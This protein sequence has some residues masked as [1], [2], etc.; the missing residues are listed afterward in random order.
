MRGLR[1]AQKISH[2]RA[3]KL[4]HAHGLAGG[5]HLVS[6]LIIERHSV[7]VERH[8]RLLQKTHSACKHSQRLQAE[9]VEL[10]Q[11]RK[12]NPFHVELR[13]GQ[14]R[15]GIAIKRRKLRQRTIPDHHARGVSGGVAVK[16]FKLQR[17]VEKL[18]DLRLAVAFGLQAFLALHRLGQGHGMSGVVGHKLR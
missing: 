1:A 8:A 5:E 17:G 15:A 18:C 6:F 14:R 4:E 9:K 2:A 16:P 3:F 7:E 11:P 12:L 10:H 13:H